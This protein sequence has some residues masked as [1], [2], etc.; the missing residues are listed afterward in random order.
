M[1][2]TKSFSRRIRTLGQIEEKQVNGVYCIA[3]I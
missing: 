2:K 1:I 3:K